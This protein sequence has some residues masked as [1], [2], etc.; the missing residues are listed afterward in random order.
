MGG[1]TDGEMGA[2]ELTG[3]DRAVTLQD[4]EAQGHQAARANELLWWLVQ[5]TGE[6]DGEFPCSSAEAEGVGTGTHR[7]GAVPCSRQAS[8]TAHGNWVSI[9][10]GITLC[11][12]YLSL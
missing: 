3:G 9:K 4:R 5:A 2:E 8:N 12:W 6:T 7:G 11:G 10:R 1:F